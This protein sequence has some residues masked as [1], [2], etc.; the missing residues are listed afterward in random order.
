MKRCSKCNIEKELTEFYKNKGG[1]DGLRSNCKSCENERSKKYFKQNRGRVN[2]W[3][4]K[5]ERKRRKTDPL[6]KMK[7]NLRSRT[8]AAFRREGYSKDTKTQE[9]LGVDWQICKAHIEKQFTK[10]MN[11]E[12][13]GEWHIDHIIPL[14]SANTEEELKK[15]CHYSNLQPLWGEE[16]LSKKDSINGQQIKF[17]I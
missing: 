11:W 5:R 13:Q 14:A 10:G 16:N 3:R 7:Q 8:Q 2:E 9:M 6:F 4:R 12:N 17:R 15:L 1:K